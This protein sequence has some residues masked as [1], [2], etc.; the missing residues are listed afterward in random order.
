MYNFRALGAPPPDPQISPC[1]CEFLATRLNPEVKTKKKR[2]KKVFVPKYTQIFMN[3]GVNPQKQTVFIAKSTKKHFLFTNS[4]VITSILGVSGLEL[5]SSSTEPVN[6]FGA[7]SSI[8]GAQFSLG[9]VQA[10]IWKSTSPECPLV[11]PGLNS[12]VF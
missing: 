3:S 12:T 7:Q 4:E 5:H 1:Y 8:G 9:G 10:V 2:K 6:F 11:A